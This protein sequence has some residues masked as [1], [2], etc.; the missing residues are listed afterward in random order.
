MPN[1]IVFFTVSYRIFSISHKDFE[2]KLYENFVKNTVFVLTSCEFF[3][4][5]SIKML[6]L[7]MRDEKKRI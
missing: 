7:P 4:L 6:K 1:I 5:S 3:F 2:P